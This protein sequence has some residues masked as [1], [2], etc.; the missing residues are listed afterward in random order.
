MSPRIRVLIADDTLVSRRGLT[1]I[2]QGEQDI[3]IIGEASTAHEATAKSV[4]LGPDVLILDLKWFDDEDAGI[5][6][7]ENLQ[8][9]APEVSVLAITAYPHLVEKARR[10]GVGPVLSKGFSKEDLVSA[11]RSIHEFPIAGIA[12]PSNPEPLPSRVDRLTPREARILRLVREQPG[13]TDD[14]VAQ[15]LGNAT[16]TVKNHL[17]N[18]YQKLGAS[19]RS[20]AVKIAIDR[21]LL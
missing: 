18:I 4:T 21:N 19:N 16:S 5:G 8:K 13:L 1:A 7:I 15:E 12:Q 3:E 6:V 14:G 10:A 9:L 11:I 17:S 2:L 20:E